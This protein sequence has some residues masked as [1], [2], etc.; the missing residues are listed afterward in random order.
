[1]NSKYVRLALVAGFMLV[2]GCGVA[3]NP[4]AKGTLTPKTASAKLA[5][6]QRSTNFKLAETQVVCTPSPL[7]CCKIVGDFT[8]ATSS[9]PSTDFRFEINT[10]ANGGGGHL[11]IQNPGP[12]GNTLDVPL[13]CTINSEDANSITVTA[14]GGGLT[15]VISGDIQSTPNAHYQ[16]TGAA[17]TGTFDSTTFDGSFIAANNPGIQIFD[18]CAGQQPAD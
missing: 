12:G 5:E 4:A 16:A 3:N 13:T 2:A 7:E 8:L 1:M 10:V 9:S 11:V 14:V 6:M 18:T 15:F 17:I